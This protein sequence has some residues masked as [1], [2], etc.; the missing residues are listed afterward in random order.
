MTEIKDGQRAG[1]ADGSAGSDDGKVPTTDKTN[2]TESTGATNECVNVSN[3]GGSCGVRN[4]EVG[5]GGEC[6]ETDQ[7]EEG[8]GEEGVDSESSDEEDEADESHGDIV[9]SLRRVVCC[10]C[11]S[12]KLREAGQLVVERVLVVGQGSPVAA[13]DDEDGKGES[14]SE[15]ELGHTS[16]IHGNGAEEVVVGVKTDE[17]SWCHSSLEAAENENGGC[18][19]NEESQETEQSRVGESLCE[20]TSGWTR[21]LEEQAFVLLWA[22]SDSD[23]TTERRAIA[24]AIAVVLNHLVLK[25]VVH[26]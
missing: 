4:G 20:I 7:T 9:E 6:E 3:I 17:R 13:V 21:G 15:D 16:D 12:S 1:N 25:L 18:V 10:S 23:L 19:G 5:G 11:G 14:V 24:I 22:H 2:E 26:C 8:E